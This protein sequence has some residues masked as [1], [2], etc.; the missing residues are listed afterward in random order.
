MGNPA[1]GNGGT[2]KGTGGTPRPPPTSG[3]DDGGWPSKAL[4]GVAGV[5][6]ALDEEG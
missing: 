5:V 1:T 3:I 2:K 4:A 6:V